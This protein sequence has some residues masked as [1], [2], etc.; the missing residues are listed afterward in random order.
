EIRNMAD[1]WY[2]AGVTVIF[3]AAGAAIA[4]VIDAADDAG[5]RKVIQADFDDRDETVVLTAAAKLFSAAVLYAVEGYRLG[6]LEGG[7]VRIGAAEGASGLSEDHFRFA[8]FTAGDLAQIVA[9]LADASIVV[10]ATETELSAF[11]TS[12]GLSIPAALR[13]RF[14]Y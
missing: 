12:H 10:P 1:S 8:V 5:G 4:S 7:A 3:T 11:A 13:E 9:Y 14:L 6:T 2:D